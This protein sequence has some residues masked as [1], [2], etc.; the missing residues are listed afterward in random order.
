MSRI[1]AIIR[2]ELEVLWELFVDYFTG[3]SS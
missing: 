2:S 3:V 1:L